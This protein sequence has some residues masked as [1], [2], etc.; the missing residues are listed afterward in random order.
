[1]TELEYHHIVTPNELIDV[2]IEH[3]WLLTS[4]THTHPYICTHTHTHTHTQTI[5]IVYATL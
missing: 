4:H 5:D 1:M 3:Q 2:G